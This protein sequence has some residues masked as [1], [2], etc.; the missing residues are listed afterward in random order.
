MKTFALKNS[1]VYLNGG[2]IAMV[3]DGDEVAQTIQTRISTFQ[4]EYFLNVNYGVPYIQVLQ[5]QE[6]VEAL[7]IAL[8]RMIDGT[9]GVVKIMDFQT[10][11]NSTTRQYNMTAV[12]NTSYNTTS[13]IIQNFEL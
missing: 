2:Q 11:L 10:T 9:V 5:S 6:T 13:T 7:N 4:G 1:D 8:K 3:Q 12:V